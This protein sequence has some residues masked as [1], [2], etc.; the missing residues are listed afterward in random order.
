MRVHAL[1][2]FESEKRSEALL[3]LR[4]APTLLFDM[5][6]ACSVGIAIGEFADRDVDSD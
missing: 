6:I 2:R 3:Y 5:C 4:K 1:S